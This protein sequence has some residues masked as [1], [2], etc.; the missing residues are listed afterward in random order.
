MIKYISK[1]Y[2]AFCNYIDELVDDIFEISEIAYFY[3]PIDN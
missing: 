1:K 3:D 2:N